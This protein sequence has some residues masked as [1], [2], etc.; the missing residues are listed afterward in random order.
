MLCPS[1]KQVRLFYKR[2]WYLLAV[3]LLSVPLSTGQTTRQ[4]VPNRDGGNSATYEQALSLLKSHRLHEALEIIRAGLAENPSDWQLYDLQ[5][6]VESSLG[7]T[8]KAEA[9]FRKVIELAPN[10]AL[11]YADLG[12]FMLSSG[13]LEEAERQFRAALD[14]EPD[15]FTARLGLGT[16]LFALQQAER[17]L[18]Y[19]AAAWNAKPKDFRAGYEYA[20]ALQEQKRAKEAQGVLAKMSVPSSPDFAVKFHALRGAVAEDLGDWHT[21][22]QEYS[23]AYDQSP[24]EALVYSSWVRAAVKSKDPE[25]IRALPSPPAGLSA[26]QHFSLGIL[27]ASVGFYTQAI[28]EFKATLKANPA[29]GAAAY[30][31]ALSYQQ[32]GN[33][34]EAIAVIRATLQQK[35]AAE[36]FNLLASMEEETGDYVQAARDFR[37]AVDLDADREEYYFDLGFEYLSHYAFRPAVDVFEAGNRRFPGS[38][39]EKVGLGYAYYG[40]HQYSEAEQAFLEAIE[41]NPSAP[42]AV[43]AWNTLTS[44]LTPGGHQKIIARMRRLAESHP[45]SPESLY[46]CGVSLFRSGE[47]MA[48][49]A[50]VRVAEEYLERAIRLKPDFAAAHLELGKLYASQKSNEKAARQFLEAV[51]I[52][53]QSAMGHYQLGQAYRKLGQLKLAQQELAQYSSLSKEHESQMSHYQSEIKKFTVAETPKQQ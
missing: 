31:L 51:R 18:P 38:L 22:V 5:G 53:P 49:P 12:V 46:Y 13:R 42:A 27:F 23:R 28:P 37:S 14:R 40:L 24:G 47:G 41:I 8:T 20:L 10:H 2:P 4:T 43:T 34:R 36:L 26:E 15:D 48:K 1:P 25:A 32:L 50:D 7:H 21:A 44:F 16:V 33:P 6:L 45:S 3:F 35:P 9:S 29:D 39:R 19:L 52:D 30:N 11:G 17:A